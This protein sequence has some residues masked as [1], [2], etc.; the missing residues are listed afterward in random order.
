L[1]DR[2]SPVSATTTVYLSLGSNLGDRLG[3]L[4]WALEQMQKQ[5]QVVSESTVWVTQPWGYDDDRDYLNMACRFDTELG[6]AALHSFLKRLEKDAGRTSPH[7]PGGGYAA[8]ELDID[9]LFYGDQVIHTKSLCVPHP[10]LH[11]RN[12]V[13]Q[14]LSEIAPDFLHPQLALSVAAL[15]L[16]SAD[17]SEPLVP[18]DGV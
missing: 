11:L 13:L 6:P 18:Y 3:H 10:R 2:M 17:K 1:T 7:G 16:Q 15:L 4:R 12:F 9:I 14:P 5:G 8:R